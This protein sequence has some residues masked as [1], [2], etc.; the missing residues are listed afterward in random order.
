VALV[1]TAK[2]ELEKVAS[3]SRTSSDKK[4]GRRAQRSGSP[5]PDTSFALPGYPRRRKYGGTS[6]KSEK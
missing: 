3:R 2:A 5:P 4:Y 6:R 1:V